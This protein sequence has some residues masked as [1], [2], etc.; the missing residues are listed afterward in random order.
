MRPYLRPVYPGAAMCGTAV[1]VLLQPGDN[2][3]MHVAAEQVQGH[4]QHPRTQDFLRRVL[5]PT[6]DTRS[7]S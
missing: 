5:H 6:G 4:P 1:T 3:M 7:L 2:W